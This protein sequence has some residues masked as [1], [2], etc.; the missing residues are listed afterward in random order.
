MLTRQ[1]MRASK[2][3]AAVSGAGRNFARLGFQPSHTP[4]A[5]TSGGEKR[6]RYS[7]AN[8]RRLWLFLTSADDGMSL[9][10]E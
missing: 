5:G 9:F 1:A 10:W 6:S 3:P 7:R 8:G 4:R 2:S